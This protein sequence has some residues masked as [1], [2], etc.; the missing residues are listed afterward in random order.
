MLSYEIWLAVLVTS[1]LPFILIAWLCRRK[2]GDKLDWV[3]ALSIAGAFSLLAFIATPWA[4]SSYY[5]RYVL[6]ALLVLAAYF[7]F[8]KIKEGR[9]QSPGAPGSKLAVT[10]KV[11][12]LFVLLPLDVLALR[13]YFYPV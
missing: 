10:L 4:M 5:L 9:P 1:G 2:A 8:R 11:G 12:A 6:I 13:T 7:S 3:L